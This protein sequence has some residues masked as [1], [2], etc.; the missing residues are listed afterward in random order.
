MSSLSSLLIVK[1]NSSV[2]S[3]RFVTF[4]PCKFTVFSGGTIIVPIASFSSRGLLYSWHMNFHFGLIFTFS[5]SFLYSIR[6][7]SVRS[8]NISFRWFTGTFKDLERSL[9][10]CHE[11]SFIE[12][13]NRLSLDNFYSSWH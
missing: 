12:S 10:P 2:L 11:P 9:T 1:F 4:V 7:C 8:V 5:L 6:L 13:K 3:V